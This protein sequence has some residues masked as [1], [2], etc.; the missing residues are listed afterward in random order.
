MAGL[1]GGGY[2]LYSIGCEIGEV[3]SWACLNCLQAHVAFFDVSGK[4]PKQIHVETFACIAD[5]PE[6]LQFSYLWWDDEGNG[7]FAWY[8][9]IRWEWGDHEA[10][11]ETRRGLDLVPLDGDL[12][13]R[14]N[15][16]MEDIPF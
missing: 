16:D 2:V 8:D 11:I 10:V 9:D 5:L 6:C 15:P 3:L 4:Y 14:R 13:G 7:P 12:Y 1:P